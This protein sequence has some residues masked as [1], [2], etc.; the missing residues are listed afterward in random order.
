LETA[1]TVRL[2]LRITASYSLPLAHRSIHFLTSLA[3]G[4]L[5][6]GYREVI[7]T[8]SSFLLELAELCPLAGAAMPVESPPSTMSPAATRAQKAFQVE[9]VQFFAEVVQ[10]FGVPK[11]VGQIYGVLYA[12]PAPLSFSDI[13]Q[14]LEISKGSASQGLQLLR[15]LGA[16]KVANPKLKALSDKL[17]AVQTPTPLNPLPIVPDGGRREYYEPELSLRKLVSGVLRERVAPLAAAG[18][19]RLALLRE[20][21]EQDGANGSFYLD[22]VKQLGS[23]RR[24]LKTVLPVLS[25]LLGPKT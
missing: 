13:V 12:S 11:S 24:R 25:A 16:I 4:S 20:L 14:Q 7:A 17:E 6:H 22:R 18:A 5:G 9:C 2:S 21:A 1:L 23:W 19:E 3:L 8:A 15:S 10:I